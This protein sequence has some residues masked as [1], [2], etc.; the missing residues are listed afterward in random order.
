M[1]N[2]AGCDAWNDEKRIY[3]ADVYGRCVSECSS[4][5]YSAACIYS[6]AHGGV[7]QNGTCTVSQGA[8]N[9]GTDR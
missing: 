2:C 6:C 3:M 5:D 8:K 7:E 9:N 4:G 1:G